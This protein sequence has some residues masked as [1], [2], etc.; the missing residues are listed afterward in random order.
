MGVAACL[1]QPGGEARWNVE[2]RGAGSTHLPGPAQVRRLQAAGVFPGA[3]GRGRALKTPGVR[4]THTLAGGV[5][6]DSP[7]GMSTLAST[8][9]APGRGFGLYNTQ[10]QLYNRPRRAA[11]KQYVDFLV[12]TSPWL[13][14]SSWLELP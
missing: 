9:Q 5:G 14:L 6:A 10:D 3:P 13:S 12:M 11:V 7:P 2:W 4:G 1:S 8:S